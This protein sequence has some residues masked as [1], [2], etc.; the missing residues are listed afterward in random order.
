M[1]AVVSI[2]L[3]TYDTYV[4]RFAIILTSYLMSTSK[5]AAVYLLVS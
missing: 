4:S 2:T 3:C 1:Q 5:T